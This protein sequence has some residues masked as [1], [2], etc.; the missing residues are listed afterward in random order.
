MTFI[1]YLCFL[2]TQSQKAPNIK[3][4]QM[5]SS[6]AL[7]SSQ[8]NNKFDLNAILSELEQQQTILITLAL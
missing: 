2:L 5:A 3:A 1:I 4:M 6:K 7:N 8:S